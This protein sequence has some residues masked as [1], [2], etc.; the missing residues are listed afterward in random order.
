MQ[1]EKGKQ[2]FRTALHINFIK[3]FGWVFIDQ[4]YDK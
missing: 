2:F 1:K 3:V 4:G